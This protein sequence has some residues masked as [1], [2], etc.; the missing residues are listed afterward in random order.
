MKATTT[1]IWDKVFT[2]NVITYVYDVWKFCNEKIHGT[3]IKE[4]K[5]L[6]KKNLI[7]S[8]SM[9]YKKSRRYTINNKTIRQIFHKAEQHFP[10]KSITALETWIE[11]A[12]NAI[13]R[14]EQD[15]RN[16]ALVKW[17]N[18]ENNRQK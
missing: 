3:N 7:L 6:C 10:K 1:Q 18:R 14:L 2:Q 9:L 12:T 16:K 17:L 11:L 5:Q 13:E 4:E 15:I 8:A